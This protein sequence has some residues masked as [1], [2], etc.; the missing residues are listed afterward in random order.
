MRLSY[1]LFSLNYV[2]VIS[3]HFFV[4]RKLQLCVD[5][6]LHSLAVLLISWEYQK[7]QKGADVTKLL[8]QASFMFTFDLDFIFRF[9][10]R[11]QSHRNRWNR[12]MI[13]S[14]SVKGSPA[15]TK[16]ELEKVKTG[17][18]VSSHEKGAKSD[19]CLERS[20]GVTKVRWWRWPAER[21]MGKPLQLFLPAKRLTPHHL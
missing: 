5:L 8:V 18:K 12:K 20:G 7:L 17:Q 15:D 13:K 14:E 16:K 19:Q 1:F 10:V 9:N 2:S 21:I 4:K 11:K 6:F 3:L